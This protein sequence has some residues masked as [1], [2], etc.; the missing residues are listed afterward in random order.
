MLPML[1]LSIIE[2]CVSICLRSTAL[3]FLR[4]RVFS[5]LK[6]MCLKMYRLLA[7]MLSM[8][9]SIISRNLFGKKILS[10]RGNQFLTINLLAG[11]N[12]Y[13]STFR[14]LISMAT[15]FRSMSTAKKSKRTYWRMLEMSISSTITDICDF[16]KTDQLS[17]LSFQG[18]KNDKHSSLCFLKGSSRT[19]RLMARRVRSTGMLWLGNMWQG[20]TM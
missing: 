20:K 17:Q 11:T 3:A 7:Q 18:N 15:N 9:S 6:I 13:I 8:P 14:G 19:F 1:F 10:Y 5:K 16:L 12:N 2:E 4:F